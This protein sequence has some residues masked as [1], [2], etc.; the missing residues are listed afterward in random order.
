MPEVKHGGCHECK[1]K[2]QGVLKS[3]Q[4]PRN[5]TVNIAVCDRCKESLERLRK[6]G[7]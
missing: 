1:S 5:P 4:D 2:E 6:G 3:I 7:K